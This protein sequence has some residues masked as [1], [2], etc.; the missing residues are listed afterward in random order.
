MRLIWSHLERVIAL[1]FE[2][3]GGAMR[4]FCECSKRTMRLIRECWERTMRLIYEHDADLTA[5]N[6]IHF[7]SKKE[8]FSGSGMRLSCFVVQGDATKL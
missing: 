1:I 8:N 3:S 6:G 2:Y 5:S 4:L 7:R